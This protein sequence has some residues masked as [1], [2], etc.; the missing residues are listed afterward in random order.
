MVTQFKELRLYLRLLVKLIDVRR[1]KPDVEAC[2][3]DRF[4]VGQKIQTE[5]FYLL[6][7]KFPT[8]S[9]TLLFPTLEIFWTTSSIIAR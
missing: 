7:G 3:L 8:R 6:L 4:P 9:I 2:R 5:L 1:R